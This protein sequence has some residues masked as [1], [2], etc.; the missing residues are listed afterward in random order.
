MYEARFIG[1]KSVGS[2]CAKYG[3]NQLEV[4]RSLSGQ[5]HWLFL[6]QTDNYRFKVTR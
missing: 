2:F 1:G 3:I 6:K 5:Y 4:G